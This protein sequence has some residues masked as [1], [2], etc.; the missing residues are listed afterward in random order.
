MDGHLSRPKQP[1]SRDT[2]IRKNKVPTRPNRILIRQFWEAWRTL[3]KTP[4]EVRLRWIWRSYREIEPG[5]II[6]PD[7]VP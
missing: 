7:D 6:Y 3:G 4:L 5:Y 2:I 1:A